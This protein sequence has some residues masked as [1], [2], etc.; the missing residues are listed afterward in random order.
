MNPILLN[1]I[2][3]DRQLVKILEDPEITDEEKIALIAGSASNNLSAKET[4]NR[5]LWVMTNLQAQADAKEARAKELKRQAD[6]LS[7]QVEW[8]KAGVKNYMELKGIKKLEMPDFTAS[9]RES[10]SCEITD[11]KKVPG[12]FIEIIPEQISIKKGEIRQDM[13]KSKEDS[14]EYAVLIKHNNIE[15]K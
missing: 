1:D 10:K 6:V 11:S 7:R 14:R 5:Y 3:Y 4:A 15:I 9:L 2:E 12:K 8:F 13:L